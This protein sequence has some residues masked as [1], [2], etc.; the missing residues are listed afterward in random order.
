MLNSLDA[1][2]L[3]P[4]VVLG[5]SPWNVNVYTSTLIV[6]FVFVV[7]VAAAAVVRAK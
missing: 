7:V 1:G 2:E 6:V 3:S 4:E 5:R